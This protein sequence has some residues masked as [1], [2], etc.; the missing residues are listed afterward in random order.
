MTAAREEVLG[1]IRTALGERRPDVAIPRDYRATDD[2]PAA[3][4]LDVLVDRLEDYK[5]SVLRCGPEEIGRTVTA[6]LDIFSA[7][8]DPTRLRILALLRSM[9]LFSREVMPAF[10]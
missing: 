2:R 7:I 5:A 1:R 4:L 9:E 10:A 6:A 8:A 3:T